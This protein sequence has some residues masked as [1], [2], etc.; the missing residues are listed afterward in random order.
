MIPPALNTDLGGT[1]IHDGQPEV[2]DFVEAVFQQMIDK[3]IELTFGFSEI[4]A[5][6]TPEVVTATFNKM[7]P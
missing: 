3:K 4:I 2:R 6:A 7:N 5:K 1:G